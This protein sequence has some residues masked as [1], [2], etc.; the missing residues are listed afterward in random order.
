MC[1]LVCVCPVCQWWNYLIVDASSHEQYQLLFQLSHHSSRAST[2]LRRYS[3]TAAKHQLADKSSRN[4]ALARP[5]SHTSIT[6]PMDLHITDAHNRTAFT[7]HVVDDDT[8]ELIGSYPA[9]QTSTGHPLAFHLTF[10]RIHGMYTSPD[11][12]ADNVRSCT[13]IS[14]HFAYSSHVTGWWADSPTH[15]LTFTR[16]DRFRAYAAA[17][18]GCQLPHTDTHEP[19]TFPWTWL[20]LAVPATDTTPELS[21]S[22]GTAKLEAQPLGA[23]YA[24]I[25]VLGV[26]EE[27]MGTTFAYAWHDSSF[28]LKLLSAAS[29]GR[30]L[31]FNRSLSD[32]TNSSDD[33]G[34]F[35][36][37]LTQHYFIESSQW[38]LLVR[39]RTYMP[40]YFRA[41]VVVEDVHDGRL[42][43]FSDFRACDNRVHVKL[44]RMH[45]DS[46]TPATLVYDG[47]ALFNAAEYAYEAALYDSVPATIA[48]LL[49]GQP[50]SDEW[51]EK[52]E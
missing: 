43:L 14:N 42:R 4:A 22:L 46:D 3:L 21:L 15:N 17:S 35:H 29:D 20:W 36:I 31:T 27:V 26:G 52:G 48:K 1:P 33:A 10:H 34:D 11:R 24:G 41:P 30:L 51:E 19:H 2:P 37:P 49:P 45:P 9:H 13:L 18:W 38:R 12:E 40:D 6:Q 8:Y 16:Q 5:L 47:P 25:S 23:L 28:Q 50:Q 44:V 32:W 7:Q 39:V